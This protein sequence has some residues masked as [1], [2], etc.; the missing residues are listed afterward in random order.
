MLYSFVSRHNA[1][2]K[3]YST[4]SSSACFSYFNFWTCLPT[5]VACTKS[6]DPSRPRQPNVP[7]KAAFDSWVFAVEM[8]SRVGRVA[9]AK[10]LY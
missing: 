3:N 7:G 9:T 5:V 6:S 2:S 4:F 10:I 8:T 1:V